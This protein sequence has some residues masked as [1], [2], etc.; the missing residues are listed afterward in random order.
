M[1]LTL[2][3]KRVTK[4]I[5]WLIFDNKIKNKRELAEKLNYTESSFSQIINGK[6]KLSERFVKKLANFDDRININWLLTGEGEM[7]KN[8]TST[9]PDTD[10]PA[11]NEIAILKEKIRAL[12]SILSEKER[13][14]QILLKSREL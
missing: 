14:I 13:T 6:V 7:L 4:A 1:A 3:I 2:D 10:T 9:T 8:Q 12:E 5:D 11:N